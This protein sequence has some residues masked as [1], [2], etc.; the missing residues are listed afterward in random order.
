MVLFGF[1]R[2]T[3]IKIQ[4]KMNRVGQSTMEEGEEE[5]TGQ[6]AGVMSRSTPG[7]RSSA[8]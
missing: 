5:H 1:C 2:G 8:M 7:G 4:I 6:S 3:Q